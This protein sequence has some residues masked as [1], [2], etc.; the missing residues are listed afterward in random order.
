[1]F[2]KKPARPRVEALVA[3]RPELAM[4]DE[5]VM[6]YADWQGGRMAPLSV[7][8]FLIV[9]P[10]DPVPSGQPMTIWLDPGVVFGNGLHPTTRDCLSAIALAFGRGMVHTALDLGTGTGLLALAAARSGADRV[11][12]VDLNRLCAQTAAANIRRNGLEDRILSIQ[13][14]AEDWAGRAADLMV[15]NL[16][17]DV[18]RHLLCAECL[19][20]KR[21]VVL[22]GLLRS[23]AKA[24]GERL[25]ALSVVIHQQWVHEGIWHTFYAERR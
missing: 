8:G 5:T 25:A 14:R 23:D 3:A 4:L 18:L 17:Y 20:T 22:S 24:V 16:H 1:L 2:F 9:A 10:W 7:A 13:G 15:A 21:H 6:S 19:D 11:L 12:A